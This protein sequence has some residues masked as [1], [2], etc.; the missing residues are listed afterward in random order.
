MVR[1]RGTQ[2][3]CWVTLIGFQ[4]CRWESSSGHESVRGKAKESMGL[5][6]PE[7]TSLCLDGVPLSSLELGFCIRWPPKRWAP[8]PASVLMYYLSITYCTSYF[9][10][11]NVAAKWVAGWIGR[12]INECV[13][14]LWKA[15]VCL[16]SPRVT[17]LLRCLPSPSLYH[18]FGFTVSYSE[19]WLQPDQSA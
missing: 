11:E 16:P 17:Y 18:S 10:C 6:T 19:Q 14:P 8:T 12:W 9:S 5:G 2:K 15:C 13:S 4:T 3:L 7:E 1:G